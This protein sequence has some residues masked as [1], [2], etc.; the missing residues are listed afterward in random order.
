M[1]MAAPIGGGSR[2]ENG[3]S[4][5]ET[6]NGTFELDRSISFNNQTQAGDGKTFYLWRLWFDDLVSSLILILMRLY[7]HLE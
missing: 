7:V 6:T 1:R 4:R 2:L 5:E 3:Q